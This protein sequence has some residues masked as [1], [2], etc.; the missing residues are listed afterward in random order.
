[1]SMA[2]TNDT[3]EATEDPGTLWSA[4]MTVGLQDNQYGYSFIGP[5]G[6]LSETSFS[7]DGSDYTV[8]ALILH[9]NKVGMSLNHAMPSTFLLRAGSADFAS[10]DASTRDVSR[11]Y[12]Y[13]WPKGNVSW[14]EGE[15]VAVSLVLAEEEEQPSAAEN[16]PPT[17]LPTISG[18]SRVGE[19]LKADTSGIADA[20]GLE[21]V[22]YN[23]QWLADDA[24]MEG[25]TASTYTLTDAEVGKTIK[26]RVSFTDDA[27]NGETLTSEAT[28]AVSAA[29]NNPA[30][31]A[32]SIRGTA[33]AGEMLTA[34]TSGIADADGLENVSYTHQ[35]LADDADIQGATGSTYTLTGAEVGKS[36]KVKVSFTDDANNQETL[37]SEATGPV[38]GATTAPGQPEHLRVFP[39]DA[40]GLDLS[41]EAP[42][43]D[44]GS[45]VTGYK[46]RWKQASGNWDTPA[47][48]SKETATGNTHTINGLTEG[49]EYAVRVIAVNA[50]GDGTPSPEATGTPRETVPPQFETLEVDGKTLTLTYDEALDRDSV[51]PTT[52]FNVTVAQ[53]ERAVDR[54]SVSGSVVTLTLASAVAQGETVVVSYTLPADESAP[55]TRDLAGNAAAGFDSTEAFN[56]TKETTPP[57][58]DAASVNGETLTL[59]YDEALDGDSVPATTAFEVSVGGAGRGVDGVDVSGSVVTLTLASAVAFGDTVTVSYTAPSDETAARIRDLA[60]SPASSF[61]GQATG[62]D[63]KP[64]LTASYHSEPESHDGEKVFTFEL[65]FSEE[66]HADFSYKTLR[67]HAFTVTGGSVQK[68]QRLQK[69]PES[70][71]GWRITVRPD[72]DG[73]VTVVLPVT[74]DCES[75]GAICTEDGRKLSNRLELTVSGPGG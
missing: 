12:I 36:I 62:N 73:D 31:G 58:L 50:V 54:V 11:L 53:V 17:G 6:Q 44:G 68:A 49:V 41:W 2:A 16:N 34:I 63:T 26:A 59:T 5:L 24:E 28:A 72:G 61:S 38:E 1:M 43:S 64:L 20:D 70:N 52:A 46:V 15:Q 7:L 66:P 56:F 60:G 30:T 74:T 39:H 3:P 42:A 8:K 48:V 55:R 14:A 57:E 37:T 22:S 65:R 10:E 23:H 19:T 21:N 27:G 45:P 13:F 9:E 18:T 40:Q 4:T 25:A 32:P 69:E 67:G 35:W 47:D 71:I 51:P 33:Q 75:T 29:A